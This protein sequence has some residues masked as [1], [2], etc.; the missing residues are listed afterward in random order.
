MSELTPSPRRWLALG[1]LCVA[2]VVIVMDTTILNVALPSMARDLH[3]RTSGLA[4]IVDAYTLVF[5]GLLLTAGSLGDRY[6]RRGAF[7]LGLALFA[8]A[9][10]ASAISGSTGTLIAARAATGV[11]AAL[12]FPSTLSLLVHVFTEVEERQRA[13]AI[14]AGTAGIGVAV[15]PIAGGLLLRHF[16]WGSVFWINVPL[17]VVALL[18]AW[19]VLPS[20]PPEARHRLDLPGAALS[21]AGLSS[22]V[23][24]I[25]VGPDHGWTS[26][27]G[28]LWFAVALLSLVAFIA[29]E[30]TSRD[31]MMDLR[32][33]RNPRF[34]AASMAVTS[35]YFALFG[36]IF[37]QT[38]HFQVVLGFDPLEAGLR[39]A[40][41][42]LVLFVVAN[43]TPRLVTRIGARTIITLGLAIVAASM[44][45]RTQFSADT[46]WLTLVINSCVFSLGM[47]LTVAP[48]TASIMGAVPP[49]RA[50]VGSAMNDTTRQVGGA[51]GVA[52]M[53]SVASSV[54][55]SRIHA[56]SVATAI[57]QGVD[58]H[59]AAA[60]FV[61]GQ[62][63][64]AVIGFGVVTLGALGVW[65]FLPAPAVAP[66]SALGDGDR[67]DDDVLA[68]TI[69]GAGRNLLHAVEDV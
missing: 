69:A 6:G 66:V 21:I 36:I 7:S 25:I 43:T 54:F 32:L 23:Y 38:Q 10:A 64:A 45:A 33:F 57:A 34:S 24:A 58:R 39:T 60:A 61:H 8:L 5:A 41:F 68:G 28:L 63:V 13:I 49:E 47:G 56:D 65:R 18:G 48:A 62:N 12:V 16:S 55:R 14:W 19:L 2:L 9:S 17:C 22:V 53:G 40:P 29:V 42:A 67:V 31:P 46:S 35:L 27:V 26:G 11:G 52:V 4:W 30:L 50:G 20:Q 15:G 59:A 44:L 1:V 3:A 51:L 37:L